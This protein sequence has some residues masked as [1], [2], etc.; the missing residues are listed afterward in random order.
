TMETLLALWVAVSAIAAVSS[1]TID[2]PATSSSV[3]RGPN[4][5]VHTVSSDSLT[6]PPHPSGS[7]HPNLNT[8]TEPPKA[9]TPRATT[10]DGNVTTASPDHTTTRSSGT[11]NSTHP[12]TVHPDNS[13]LPT[14]STPTSAPSN[15]TITTENRT[16]TDGSSSNVTSGSR[17]TTTR[18][19]SS[20]V[21]R[22]TAQP[23]PP[24]PASRAVPGW[25]VALLVL[26]TLLLL[27]LLLLLIGLLAW[28]CC[29]GGRHNNYAVFGSPNHRDDIPLYSTHGRFAGKQY[30]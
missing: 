13:T 9:E 21:S 3:T 25:G 30:V 16:T 26:A 19:S 4:V 7:P 8:T 14:L 23:A 17:T 18:S 15:S 5:T 6:T 11:T 27:L 20:S 28:C 22:S 1:T 10:L 2:P 12:S 24:A 29:Y